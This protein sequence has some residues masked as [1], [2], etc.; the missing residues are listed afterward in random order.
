MPDVGPDHSSVAVSFNMRRWTHVSRL[1]VAGRSQQVTGASGEE[2]AHVTSCSGRSADGS[3][4]GS[5]PADAQGA[6]GLENRV[7]GADL[8]RLSF[9]LPFLFP[10][11][12]REIHRLGFFFF[13]FRSIDVI[14]ISLG[15][16][17]FEFLRMYPSPTCRRIEE[18]RRNCFR[19]KW[20]PR[21]G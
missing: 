14:R 15:S 18:T 20:Y 11:T 21:Q 19:L 2:R 6:T 3:S 13:F 5:P 12:M 9:L 7:W 10:L 4:R 17:F 1:E 8:E 16:P